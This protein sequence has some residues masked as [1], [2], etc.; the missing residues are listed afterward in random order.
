MTSAGYSGILQFNPSSSIGE[1]VCNLFLL[2]YLELIVAGIGNISY[3]PEGLFPS[4]RVAGPFLGVI[5]KRGIC[6]IGKLFLSQNFLNF[7]LKG[8]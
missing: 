7:W 5:R 4:H 3:P 2:Y 8:L 1:K 6:L